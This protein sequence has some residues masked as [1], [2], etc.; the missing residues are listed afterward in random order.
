MAGADLRRRVIYLHPS[1]GQ[2]PE[3]C[4]RIFTHELFHF[5]W[6]RLGNPPRASWKA[7]LQAELD[8]DAR[9]ELGWSS[10]WRKAEL[11][12]RFP[13][14][15]CE[16]FCDTAAWLHSGVSSHAEYTLAARWRTRRRE[17]FE[18]NLP[19]PWRG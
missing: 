16:S 4:A 12:S 13:N 9:G 10:E 18:L 6:V 1:L 17:W 2:Q 15:A 14:Y 7:L 11:P 19:R 3:E 8:R 5:V